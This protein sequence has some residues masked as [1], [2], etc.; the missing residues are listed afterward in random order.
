MTQ[1]SADR[2][3]RLNLQLSTET[4]TSAAPEIEALGLEAKEFFVLDGIEKLPYPAE[5]SRH[6]SM[7]KP[8]VAMY[9]KSLQA[10]GLIDRAIDEKDMRRHRIELTP[11]GR[12]AVDEARLVLAR[13]YG[14]WL[15]KLEEHE[16][17]EFSRI[18]EKLAM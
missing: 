7:T 8:T 5:L 6:L 11:T 4:L 13:H 2:I 16:Q 18:L 12:K 10:R 3:F 9:L 1:L 15:A 17:V 14:K